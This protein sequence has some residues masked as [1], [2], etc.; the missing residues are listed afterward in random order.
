M[1][2]DE[3]I[4]KESQFLQAFESLTFIFVDDVLIFCNGSRGDAIS[5]QSILAFWKKQPGC[6]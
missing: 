4:L 1:Q 3:G 2:K 5:L 6:S